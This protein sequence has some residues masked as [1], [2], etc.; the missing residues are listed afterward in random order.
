MLSHPF[1]LPPGPSFLLGQFFSG[2]FTLFAGFVYLASI[3][4]K[5]L[6]LNIPVWATVSC[7]ILA[8]P[9]IILAHAQYR[10]WRDGKKAASLGA[11]LAPT[12]PTRLPGG[13]DL[14][15]AWM[16]AFRTGYVGGYIYSRPVSRESRTFADD[17]LAGWLAEG[18]QTI[19]VRTLWTSRVSPCP[20]ILHLRSR[21]T[22]SQIMTTDP[23]GIKVG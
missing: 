16:E 6:G 10:Y 15:A 8:F 21:S 14:L 3:G 4:N 18:G 7:P 19:D 2:E 12:V 11:R 20:C 17:P 1:K 5:A 23:Q 13:V 9:C 22:Q